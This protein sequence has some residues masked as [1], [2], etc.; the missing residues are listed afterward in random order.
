VEKIARERLKLV[1]PGETAVVVIPEEVEGQATAGE[2]APPES[3][4]EGSLPYWQQWA[5]LLLGSGE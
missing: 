5:E 1:Q 2:T 3:A 4:Q